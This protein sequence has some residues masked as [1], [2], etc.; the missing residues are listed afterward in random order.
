MPARRRFRKPRIDKKKPVTKRE[1]TTIVKKMVDPFSGKQRKEFKFVLNA[2]IGSLVSPSIVGVGNSFQFQL[3]NIPGISDYTDLYDEYRIDRVTVTFLPMAQTMNTSTTGAQGAVFLMS[4]D[5]NDVFV[6]TSQAYMLEYADVK[7]QPMFR[8]ARISI[9]PKAADAIYNGITT[10]YGTR[11]GWINTSN[12]DVPHYGLKTFMTTSAT[13]G[14]NIYQIYY[15]FR[16]RFRGV[17]TV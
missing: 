17:R 13:P 3:N 14:Q 16:V 5:N 15:V 6:P 10:A 1:V 2:N 12:A 7:V 11:F 4:Q 9:I 8:Q